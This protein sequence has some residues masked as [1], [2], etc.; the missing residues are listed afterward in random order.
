MVNSQTD[1]LNLVLCIVLLHVL[2]CVKAKECM[3]YL[4]GLAEQIVKIQLGM[5]WH[6]QVQDG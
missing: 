1:P 4:S 2:S 5:T 6:W 3:I